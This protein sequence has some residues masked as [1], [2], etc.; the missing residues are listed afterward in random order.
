M[1]PELRPQARRRHAS[2]RALRRPASPSCRRL[3]GVQIGARVEKTLLHLNRP[4]AAPAADDPYKDYVVP[5]D[6]VW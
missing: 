2:H 6:L 5:D 1:N 4:G 3:V